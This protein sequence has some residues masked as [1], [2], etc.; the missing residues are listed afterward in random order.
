[1]KRCEDLGSQARPTALCS[2]LGIRAEWPMVR[3]GLWAGKS[4]RL[5]RAA[6][7]QA[8][9]TAG[10]APAHRGI[11]G[12]LQMLRVWGWGAGW[13]HTEPRG[14]PRLGG[15]LVVAGP[16]LWCAFHLQMPGPPYH[17]VPRRQYGLLLLRGGAHWLGGAGPP[18]ALEA[19]RFQLSQSPSRPIVFFQGVF[20]NWE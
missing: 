17:V 7:H 6:W 3:E 20:I 1:M 12:R 9:L 16:Q 19:H 15:L 10:L 18:K 2:C 13:G 5:P 4:I 8:S 11:R 14:S